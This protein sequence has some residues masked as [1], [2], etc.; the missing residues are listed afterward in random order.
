MILQAGNDILHQLPYIRV[1]SE[2]RPPA[3]TRREMAQAIVFWPWSILPAHSH[4]MQY[5]HLRMGNS[6]GMSRSVYEL[7]R[8]PR[9]SIRVGYMRGIS[10]SGVHD[11]HVYVLH[12][13]RANPACRVLVCAACFLLIVHPVDN[14]P[15]VSHDEWHW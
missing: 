5:Q 2:P 13:K 9:L 8:A 6:Y 14:A 12:A 4:M 7:R 10:H 3:I 11:H 1:P 15:T